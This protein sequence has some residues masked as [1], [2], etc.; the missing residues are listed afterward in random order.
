M[1]FSNMLFYKSLFFYCQTL[2]MI[3]RLQYS[4]RYTQCCRHMQIPK[5]QTHDELKG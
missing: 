3:K 1:Y 5:R 4:K 2:K